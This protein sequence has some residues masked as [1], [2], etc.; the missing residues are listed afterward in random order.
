MVLNRYAAQWI[1]EQCFEHIVGPVYEMMRKCNLLE[2]KSGLFAAF[3]TVADAV[4][5]AKCNTESSSMPAWS[6]SMYEDTV[7]ARLWLLILITIVCGKFHSWFPGK[8][9]QLTSLIEN[10]LLFLRIGLMD[11][12][13]ICFKIF[14]E[15]EKERI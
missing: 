14:L 12:E 8:N 5:F 2:Y 3:P 11:G 6:S 1:P 4:H 7:V 13:G 15:K 9:A 10:F